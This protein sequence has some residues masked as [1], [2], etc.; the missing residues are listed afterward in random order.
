MNLC[1]YEATCVENGRLALEELRKPEN[2]F[3]LLLLDLV[4]PEMDGFELLTIMKS[5]KYLMDIPVIVM[6]ANESKQVV[7]QSL[8]KDY[9]ELIEC[10]TG[11]Y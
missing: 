4:M 1:N 5:D 7:S 8:S 6:S 3:D 9:F 11:S 10:R 2:D